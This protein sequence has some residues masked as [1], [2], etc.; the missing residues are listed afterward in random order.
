MQYV[1]RFVSS[2]YNTITPNIN[3]ATLSGAID[4]IVVER[5]VEVEED[6]PEAERA[7]TGGSSK[8]TVRR[9]ELASTPFHVRFGKMSVLR[10]GERKVT[11]H[12]NNS[13]E[14]LPFA[15]KIGEQGEAFF[16]VEIDDEDERNQ[17]PDDLVTSPIL[18]AA[19]SPANSPGFEPIP[20]MAAGGKD[21]ADSAPQDPGQ[22]DPL[23]LNESPS[24]Q[25]ATP[26]AI[27]DNDDAATLR[28]TETTETG[29][30]SPPRSDDESTPQDV[31]KDSDL[32]G[33]GP[34]AGHNSIMSQLGSAASMAGGAVGAVGR[35]V[36]VAGENP[37]LDKLAKKAS[38]KDGGDG[39]GAPVD[40][41]KHSAHKYAPDAS[42]PPGKERQ[43]EAEDEARR[44]PPQ[45]ETERL[46]EKMREKI[47]K[48]IED[49]EEMRIAEG[50]SNS[51][52]DT[53]RSDDA[54]SVEE[55]YPAPFGETS[56]KAG[57]RKPPSHEHPARTGS[58]TFPVAQFEH[59]QFIAGR[60]L[61]SHDGDALGAVQPAQIDVR[62]VEGRL[63]KASEDVETSAKDD[64]DASGSTGGTGKVV[65]EPAEIGHDDEDKEQE[66]AITPIKG[67]PSS[68]RRKEDLQYLFDMDG[69]KMTADGEDLAFA[70]GHRLA[71]EM[72]LSRRH[73]G[74]EIHPHIGELLDQAHRRE[75]E[76]LA[77]DGSGSQTSADAIPAIPPS[78]AAE[79]AHRFR[80]GHAHD[81]AALSN[82]LV[83]LA[84]A[85]RGQSGDAGEDVDDDEE[86][87]LKAVK[88]ATKSKRASRRH[89]TD[90]SLS[91]TEAGARDDETDSD[92]EVLRPRKS[93]H[94]RAKST[95]LDLEL[96]SA[97]RNALPG[98]ATPPKSREANWKWGEPG[99]RQ[100]VLSDAGPSGVEEDLGP[101][102]RFVGSDNNPYAFRVVLFDTERFFEM[103]LCFKDG[104]GSGD[105]D[106]ER[107]EFKD[108]RISFQRFLDDPDV[109]NDE[110]LVVLY[111]GRFLTW[112]DSSTVLATLSLYRRVYASASQAEA[113][114]GV[115]S[116]PSAQGPRASVWSRWWNRN[117]QP[118]AAQP[119]PFERESTAPPEVGAP[120]ARAHAP[121]PLE[122]AESDTA[123][124]S[125]QNQ[126][127]SED[128]KEKKPQPPRDSSKS[129]TYAKT[130]R[131]TSDQLKSLNLKKGANTITFSVTS[132]YSG[133]ATCTAR[134]FLWESAHQIVV[135]DIDGTITKSDALGHV[136]TMIGRDWTH[137]GVAK[138]YT[139]IARN[140]YRI[141]YLT[142]RAIGQADTT[143][144]YLR[145]INQNN[146]R[147]PDGPVIMSP[148]RLIASLHR[149]VILR[150]P[151][152]FKMACLRD[153][154]RLFGADPR[155]AQARPGGSWPGVGDGAMKAAK[156]PGA[157]EEASPAAGAATA[158]ANAV[159]APASAPTPFYAGFG[160]RITDAL[161]YRSVNIPSSRI[162]TI[163]TNGEVKMELLELAGYKS[164][165]IHMTDLVDQMFPPITQRSVENK[166]GKPEYNDFNFWRPAIDVGI[167]LPPDEDLMPT[168]PVSPALS[169]RSG[170]SVRSAPPGVGAGASGSEAGEQQAGQKE[171]RLSRFGLGSLGLSRKSSAA[172]MAEPPSSPQSAQRL[173]EASASAPD[174]HAGAGEV[175]RSVS[176][177]VGPG[178]TGG[179]EGANPSS[180][181]TS[182]AS[183]F[184]SGTSS[185]IA[186]WRRSS[187]SA[188]RA[189]SPPGYGGRGSGREPGPTSPL[190]GPVITAEPE[191][192][193]D[194][195]DDVSDFDGEGDEEDGSDGDYD[196]EEDDEDGSEYDE[197]EDVEG[198]SVGDGTGSTRAS[199]QGAVPIS[200]A[201][202]QAAGSAREQQQAAVAAAAA[203]ALPRTRRGRRNNRSA[204]RRGTYDD[205]GAEDDDVLASG[206]VQFD[207]R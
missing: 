155:H 10:P 187:S 64:A 104:F 30:T 156:G 169:A 135:S 133:V 43:Q 33:S 182:M 171:G 152:V 189:V 184:G 86:E 134:I 6:V 29:I 132:S 105:A 101:S 49:E 16:V 9:L 89:P 199:G 144:D 151:E 158:A 188:A 193:E 114:E 202:T 92:D 108:S 27:S 25:S 107:E 96:G 61:P 200:G 97:A 63:R 186:P 66:A 1:G 206:E 42:N 153:I 37:R 94:A 80:D 56:R 57:T 32:T 194:D 91:D 157:G 143:R 154:A 168:P 77:E 196:E 21:G 2:V 14:P 40:S 170:K 109:V 83:R 15:M 138:L 125:Q 5:D 117:K 147:L 178:A 87:A 85:L 100:R 165:Y 65:A 183:S 47:D 139:D 52:D 102:A 7:T 54:G 203:P 167:E 198:E 11:L 173:L 68:S 175:E 124:L 51:G 39:K 20:S 24:A 55:A 17:I 181:P 74:D 205:F 177:P 112:V 136:F 71:D 149:E 174:L 128:V 160:N 72:P 103:S 82:D 126:K 113:G 31:P 166:V 180:P 76:R 44:P 98:D 58:N 4:V 79:E 161:S 201:S 195:D 84:Q 190:V 127:Q 41:D 23:D 34:N 26:A 145:G 162:F 141:M 35:A 48:L 116:L 121:I 111:E 60:R 95:A 140:G 45:N 67:G 119:P 163:D 73:G 137:L 38:R 192:E 36:G 106:E 130:L 123:L 176:A 146:Y 131:L 191:S 99:S 129:K 207:W 53:A 13:S 142:S 88:P 172:T 159:A 204:Q 28:S 197:D 70:E 78:T 179:E 90:V 8:R 122:R 118:A 19:S 69:Y 164:S 148:D 3:P 120:A 110:R 59:G 75:R 46:E 62:N 12:L 93:L 150:K 22:I 115:D 185:W 18:S 81:E 50:G